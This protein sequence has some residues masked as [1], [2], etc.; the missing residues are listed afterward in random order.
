MGAVL[1]QTPSKKQ[2]Q[3]QGVLRIMPMILALG[4]D[5]PQVEDKVRVYGEM[6]DDADH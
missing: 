4:A 5:A 1:G 6:I 2:I 3:E